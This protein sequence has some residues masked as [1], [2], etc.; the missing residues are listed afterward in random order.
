VTSLEDVPQFIVFCVVES[1]QGFFWTVQC[2][3]IQHEILGAQP[4]DEEEITPYPQN[5]QELPLKFVS[6]GQPIVHVGF[7]LN[8]PIEEHEI[9]NNADNPG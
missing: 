6:L 7:D 2:E 3:I 9:E 8:L 1:F 5:G 4:A